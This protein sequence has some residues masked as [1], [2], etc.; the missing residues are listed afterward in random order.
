MIN[1]LHNILWLKK[2]QQKQHIVH[3]LETFYTQQPFFFHVEKQYI[4]IYTLS[5][6]KMC[7]Q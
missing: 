6:I 2:L 4:Y 5:P 3:Y 1:E 7:F